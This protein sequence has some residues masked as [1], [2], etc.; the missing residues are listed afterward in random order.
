MNI[1]ALKNFLG[2]AKQSQTSTGKLSKKTFS[3]AWIVNV[4]GR[5][6]LMQAATDERVR[7]NGHVT[8]Q[9]ER[10]KGIVLGARK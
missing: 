5:K 8:I 3:G 7:S 2:F 1:G 4:R 9:T 6:K 10:G